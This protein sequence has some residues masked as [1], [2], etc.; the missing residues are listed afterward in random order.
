MN[1]TCWRLLPFMH[2][3]AS[4]SDQPE[5]DPLQARSALQR[6]AQCSVMSSLLGAR[7]RSPW[8]G[9]RACATRL[10]IVSSCSEVPKTMN[11]CCGCA[12]R[13]HPQPCGELFQSQE[14]D[15]PLSREYPLQTGEV[16]WGGVPSSSRRRL[17]CDKTICPRSRLVG[18]QTLCAARPRP[19]PRP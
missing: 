4:D 5:A 8:C 11:P 7:A 15:W 6:Y 3:I 10:S 17:P 1:D 12:P 9:A 18:N 19:R 16:G 2:R 13:L 14:F